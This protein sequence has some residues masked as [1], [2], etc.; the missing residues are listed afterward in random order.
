MDDD[1]FKFTTIFAAFRSP[2]IRM[3]ET[4]ATVLL[5]SPARR[6]GIPFSPSQRVQLI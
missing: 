1:S 5:R 2:S 3:C 6:A 4:A